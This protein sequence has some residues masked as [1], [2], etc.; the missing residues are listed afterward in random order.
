MFNFIKDGTYV[1]LKDNWKLGTD[2]YCFRKRSAEKL[3]IAA[4]EGDNEETDGKGVGMKKK[5]DAASI[6]KR[7]IKKI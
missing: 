6:C 3:K 4:C 5:S 2:Q 1:E 7:I